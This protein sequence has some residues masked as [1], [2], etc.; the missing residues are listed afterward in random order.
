MKEFLKKIK[1]IDFLHTELEIS[2][3]EFVSNLKAQV[4]EGSTSLIFGSFDMFSSGKNQYRGEVHDNGFKIKRKKKAFDM[5]VNLAV[6][7]GKI[8]QKDDRLIINTEI[9]GFNDFM[10][11]FYIICIVI[12]GLF[13]SVPFEADNEGSPG[14]GFILPFM[15]VHAIFMMGIPYF[16]MRRSVK[17]LKYDLEREFFYLTKIRSGI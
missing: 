7:S 15:S 11:P 6:A 2:K 13:L 9:N 1:L 17:R 12:Y 14:P 16:I 8:L 5:N 10:V 4:D 3:N